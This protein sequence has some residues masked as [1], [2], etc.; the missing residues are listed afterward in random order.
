MRIFP[1]IGVVLLVQGAVLALPPAEP[2]ALRFDFGPGPVA[3][4][5]ESLTGV[6]PRHDPVVLPPLVTVIGRRPPDGGPRDLGREP[7]Q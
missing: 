7:S 2:G 4:Y 1:R 5:L 6:D 3:R